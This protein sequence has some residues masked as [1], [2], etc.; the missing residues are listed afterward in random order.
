MTGVS[1]KSGRAFGSHSDYDVALGG[2]AIFARAKELGIPLRDGGSRTG[3]L[4]GAHL[5]ALGLTGLRSQLS[6]MAGREVSFM[7]YSN[8]E[9]AMARSPSLLARACGC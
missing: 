4:K 5:D 8:I 1:F 6:G 2:D 3:P 7:T 9:S